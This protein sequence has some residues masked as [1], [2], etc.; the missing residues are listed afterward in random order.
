ME[1]LL[2]M[3][4]EEYTH[5]STGNKYLLLLIAN[6]EATKEGWPLTSVYSDLEGNVW[7]RPTE[8]FEAKYKEV[9]DE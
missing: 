9:K 1:C 6:S 2:K 8:E 5:I 7:A 3:I 4:N